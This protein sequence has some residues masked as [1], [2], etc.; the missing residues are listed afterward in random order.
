MGSG[1]EKSDWLQ[2][3]Q[4][5]AF[6]RLSSFNRSDYSLKR[7]EEMASVLGIFAAIFFQDGFLRLNSRSLLPILIPNP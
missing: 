7:I 6:F 2:M 3:P 4:A 5:R 1:L